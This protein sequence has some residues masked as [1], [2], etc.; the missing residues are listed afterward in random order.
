MDP[1]YLFGEIFET[2]QKVA[3]AK[4]GSNGFLL[5]IDSE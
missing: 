2:K 3:L 5:S 4:S 1:G